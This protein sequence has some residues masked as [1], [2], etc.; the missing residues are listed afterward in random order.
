MIR[1]LTHDLGLAKR[2]IVFMHSG[3]IGLGRLDGGFD[4]ITEAFTEVLSEGLLVIPSFT[5][6][7]CKKEPFDPVTTECPKEVGSY[8]Q[9]AWKDQRFARSKDP[10]FAVAALKND[11]NQG[12]IEQM[13]DIGSSCF[14]KRSVFDHMCKIAQER[15]GYVLLLGGAHSDAVF[16]TTFIHYVEEKMG[17]PSRYL[18]KF[19]NPADQN[20]YVEQLCRFIS[21]EEY[22]AV[23][24]KTQSH[25]SFP[26]ASDYALLG[27]DLVRAKLLTR[28]PF[29]YSESRMVRIREFCDFIEQ[30]LRQ[31]PD[32]FVGANKYAVQ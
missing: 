31:Y 9:A 1:H 19:Y 11:F 26:I 32:Y 30:K 10:N 14:G 2:D 7:W 3:V 6:S 23:T 24:G 29:G 27:E 21:A 16:R 13:F 5:Y 8:A 22:R 12:M 17:V 18:K 25:Y 28:K 15:R 4:T 20:E